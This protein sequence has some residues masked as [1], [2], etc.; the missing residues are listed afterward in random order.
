MQS[1]HQQLDAFQQASPKPKGHSTPHIVSVA[2]TETYLVSALCTSLVGKRQIEI[3]LPSFN[4]LGVFLQP[5]AEMGCK[6][7]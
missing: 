7:M 1:G 2:L 5:E 6:Q 4:V 3:W